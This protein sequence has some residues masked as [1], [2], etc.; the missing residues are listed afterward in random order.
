MPFIREWV[1]RHAYQ[2]TWFENCLPDDPEQFN[3]IVL[4]GGDGSINLFFNK[5]RN[6]TVPVGLIRAGTGNDFYEHLFGKGDSLE[7]QLERAFGAPH[8]CVD[9]GICN[10]NLFMNGLGIGFD[11]DVVKSGLGK[12]FFTGKAAYFSTVLTRLFAYRE[13]EVH[14]QTE[15]ESWDGP[16]FMLSAAN[17]STYGGG[18]RVAPHADMQDGLLELAWVHKITLWQRMRYLPVIEK[19]EHLNLPFIQ[20][21]QSKKLVLSS[22]VPLHA[23][24]DGEWFQATRFEVEILPSRFKIKG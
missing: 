5:F 15:S 18:F 16:L 12:K 7:A 13:T 10:N 23:H 17:G 24:L 4:A 1:N 19:G 6:L 20:Y 14:I 21:V 2:V 8:F 9:A 3:G 22:P 11:G